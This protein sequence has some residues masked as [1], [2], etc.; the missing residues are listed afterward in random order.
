MGESKM[1]DAMGFLRVIC[2]AEE[3]FSEAD[4]SACRARG[5]I[6]LRTVKSPMARTM[7]Q[8]VRNSHF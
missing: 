8:I 5:S 6:D 7:P 2:D 1:S 4:G 3:S